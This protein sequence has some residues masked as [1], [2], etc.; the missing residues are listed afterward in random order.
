MY[1]L[2]NN[3]SLSGSAWVKVLHI[4]LELLELD[5]C[6]ARAEKKTNGTKHFVL[7]MPVNTSFGVC[8]AIHTLV[9]MS[10]HTFCH[11]HA[12]ELDDIYS[13]QDGKYLNCK[14]SLFINLPTKSGF[15]VRSS[16]LLIV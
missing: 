10:I 6:N 4:V 8:K 2:L 16:S 5:V 12:I 1:L 3:D 13:L 14:G 15:T 11:V 7:S 9:L